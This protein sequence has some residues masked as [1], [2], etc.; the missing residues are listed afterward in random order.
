[1]SSKL[2][3]HVW[4]ACA[5]SGIKGTKLMIMARLAD[6]SNEEGVCQIE[7]EAVARQI[8][9]GESTIYGALSELEK[10]GWLSRQGMRDGN[11]N[12][13]NLYHLN[14]MRLEQAAL[15]PGG[16]TSPAR[17]RGTP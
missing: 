15:A 4:E 9:A 10:S 14:V 2:L 6:Y 3:G 11:R 5:A 12:A 7:I 17:S 1:M 13:A 16:C 8:G